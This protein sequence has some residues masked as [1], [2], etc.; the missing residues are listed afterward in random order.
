LSYNE[1]PYIRFS[2]NNKNLSLTTIQCFIQR[3]SLEFFPPTTL[4]YPIRIKCYQLLIIYYNKYQVRKIRAK[5]PDLYYDRFHKTKYIPRRSYTMVHPLIIKDVQK[6]KIFV[7]YYINTPSFEIQIISKY[8]LMCPTISHLCF[9]GD[10][11]ASLYQE[12]DNSSRFASDST[13]VVAYRTKQQNL[14]SGLYVLKWKHW[15]FNSFFFK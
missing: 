14:E 10:A 6:S 2:S 15:S 13:N 7:R 4:C 9:A 3:D 12:R 1:N 8:M 11:P 5:A